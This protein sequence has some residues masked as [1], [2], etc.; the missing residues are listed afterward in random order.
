MSF[1][2]KLFGSIAPE[3][4]VKVST[5][6]N[7]PLIKAVNW[8]KQDH[9]NDI[10]TNAI[11]R[12][13][14]RYIEMPKSD[15]D[16][17]MQ[18]L[19]ATEEKNR[20]LA[21][22][23]AA[24]DKGI[25]LEK[26]GDIDGAIAI[27]ERNIKLG[28]P[29]TH[30]YDRLLVLCHQLNRSDDEERIASLACEM[31]PGDGKYIKRLQKITNQYQ[32]TLP[33]EAHPQKGHKPTIGEK[34]WTAVGKLIEFD[35]YHDLPEGESTLSWMT[36]HPELMK[37]P[38]LKTVRKHREMFDGMLH[39]AQINEDSGRLDLAAD[40]Y[41]KMI[42][43]ECFLTKPYERLIAIYHKAKLIQDER[44]VLS[45][46]IIF[47]TDFEV[48]QKNYVLGLA[49]KYGKLDFA[50]SYISDGKR[51]QYYMGLFDLYKP[52]NIVRKWNIRLERLNKKL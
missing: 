22:T 33:S 1:L 38:G 52:Y 7:S 34:Y 28:Y 42:A 40:I 31:F 8:D 41:E 2:D 35:F 32:E 3:P 50:K 5:G 29:A 26:K 9:Y 24:N 21:E 18:S 11:L 12:N 43:E 47:L 23:A 17:M 4:T 36:S 30:S 39:D 13:G 16:A 19:A 49:A 44:R 6:V 14:A 15:Y 10:A 45:T 25:A 46:A 27:Y 20:R 51:I 48:R 37:Q